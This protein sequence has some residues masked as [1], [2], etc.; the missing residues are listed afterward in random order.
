MPETA[1][2]K[3]E[4]AAPSY[5]RG[6]AVPLLNLTLSQALAETARKFP[7]REALIVCHEGVRLTWSELD[8]E[9]TRTARGLAGLGL[10]PGHSV[11]WI[12]FR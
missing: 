1:E 3:S 9:A 6:A 2:R 5:L 4:A 7:E 11:S 8:R 10:R 12:R